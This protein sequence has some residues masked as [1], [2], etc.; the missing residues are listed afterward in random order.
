MYRWDHYINR[1]GGARFRSLSAYEESLSV[2]FRSPHSHLSGIA[3]KDLESYCKLVLQVLKGLRRLAA[4][5][6]CLCSTSRGHGTSVRSLC[7]TLEPPPAR[8]LQLAPEPRHPGDGCFN[9]AV[10]LLQCLHHSPVRS[11]SPR[12]GHARYISSSPHCCMLNPGYQPYSTYP[13]LSPSC[14]LGTPRYFGT[15]R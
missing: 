11:S 7:D 5:Y 15:P 14:C 4:R 2:P 8:L 9:P 13:A 6:F 12:S 3:F 10:A 1:L